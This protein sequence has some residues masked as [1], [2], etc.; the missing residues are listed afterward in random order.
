MNPNFECKFDGCCE[1][2][3]R[4]FVVMERDSIVH[5]AL[6]CGL[7]DIRVYRQLTAIYMPNDYKIEIK[8][9][10]DGKWKNCVKSL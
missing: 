1:S 10:E 5:E 2:A 6:S 3:L 9:M 8:V 4:K 7:H